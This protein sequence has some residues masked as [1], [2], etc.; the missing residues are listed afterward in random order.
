M[1]PAHWAFVKEALIKS[2]REGVLFDREY[3]VR[4]SKAGNLMKPIY[5]SSVIMDDKAQQL[6]KCASKLNF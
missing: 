6:K 1:S 3:W 4:H 5:T 2:I